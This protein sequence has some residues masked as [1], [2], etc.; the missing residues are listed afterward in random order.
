MKITKR[1]LEKLAALN[2]EIA[3]LTSEAELIK[4]KLK[5][6]GPGTYTGGKFKAVVS[7][8]TTER[9]DTALVKKLLAPAALALATKTSTSLRVSLYDL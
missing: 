8:A 7:E 6:A 4:R 2:A 9:L 1:D 5:E 3:E